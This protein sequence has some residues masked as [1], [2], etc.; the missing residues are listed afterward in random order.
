[1]SARTAQNCAAKVESSR[2]F[3]IVF[4]RGRRSAADRRIYR[5]ESSRPRITPTSTGGGR[6]PSF[7]G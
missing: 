6:P 2:L 3:T 5:P 4:A 7:R 1:M